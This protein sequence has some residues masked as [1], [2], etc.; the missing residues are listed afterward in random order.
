MHKII[1]P[2]FEL[3]L[4]SYKIAT[5]EDN[6][7]F[8]AQV[9]T[10]YSFPFNFKLTEELIKTFG[11]LLDDNAKFITTKF[12]VLYAFGNQLE[13]AVFEIETQIG[14]AITATFRF[15]FDD[16]PNY[17]KKLS[18]LP[19]QETTITDVYAHALTIINQ[20][21]PAVNYNYPQIES[22]KYDVTEET[23]LEFLGKINNYS[24]G[25]F[26]QN[27]FTP[28]TNT[29]RNIMQPLPYLLH[30]L[31]Q[32]FLDAG[33]TLK[34]DILTNEI[35]KQI[36]IFTDIDYFDVVNNIESYLLLKLDYDS[37]DFENFGYY[38]RTFA[39]EP[40]STYKITGQVYA[41]GEEP[42]I[43]PIYEERAG[44]RL[45]YSNI[46]YKGDF[47]GGASTNYYIG[48]VTRDVNIEFTT[49]S[50][51]TATQKLDFYSETNL[52]QAYA[53]EFI[54]DLKI[55]KVI[56]NNSDK[57]I[58][59]DELNLKN[60]VPDITFGVF[61]NEWIKLLNLDIVV[62]KQD[63]YLN[64]LENQINYQDAVNLTD[65]EV[66]KPKKDF[67]RLDSILL[68]FTEGS[69]T[70]MTYQ[71]VFVNRESL[72]YTETNVNDDT[73]TIEIDIMPLTQK[74]KYIVSTAYFDDIGGDQKIYAVLYNG[75]QNS[76]NTTV[77]IEPILLPAIH[78]LFHK[79]WFLFRLFA[80]NYQWAFKMF[81]EEVVKLKKKVF[82][83]GRYH[84]IKTIDKT[85]ISEDLFE[86]EIETETLP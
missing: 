8:S 77:D 3:D 80:I 16:F 55:E 34:G 4:S 50:D 83:Y 2:S 84:V 70:L 86:V 32:G 68:K 51:T 63:V 72:L 44:S 1:H 15:G 24:G 57:I 36:L 43:T 6:Y 60:V 54:F 33:Y 9:F 73:E 41:R 49:D 10:K 18:E 20:T 59:K 85:Q 31:K 62:D 11:E 40:D 69:D 58:V 66:L 5:V 14:E 53:D 45:G 46:K 17:D 48:E 71:P 7:W 27:E 22:T 75:L 42:I 76:L 47:L 81:M 37:F 79:K 39:L 35:V 26:Y 21:Y 28:T 52:G 64:F 12:D 67:T 23:W 25:A 65:K 13:N 19:L 38:T 30:I 61:T 82:A 78:Q 56:E 29:N 74:T